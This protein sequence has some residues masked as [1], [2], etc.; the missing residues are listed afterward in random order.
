M[1]IATR[2]QY[3]HRIR[4]AV[5]A[6]RNVRLFPDLEIP[7]S[8]ARTWITRGRRRVV[9]AANERSDDV[10]TLRAEMAV[11]RS[12]TEMYLAMTSILLVVIRMFG[13][14]LETTRIPEGHDKT[15]RLRVVKVASR[16]VSLHRL[17]KL[18]GLSPSRDHAWKRRKLSCELEDQSSCPRSRPAQLTAFKVQAIK[19]HVLDPGLRHM[20]VRALSLLA[21]R[22]DKVFASDSTWQRLIRNRGW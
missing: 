6:T 8:T 19:G 18:I 11:L 7:V 4:R 13:L 12:K 9:T 15:K 20:S 5:V 2:R 21:Q 17:L 16:H 10:A 14:S 22:R 3:D 1:Q